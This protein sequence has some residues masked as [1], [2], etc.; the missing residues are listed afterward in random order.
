MSK[1]NTVKGISREIETDQK[2]I[3]LNSGEACIK[4]VKEPD[5]KLS[6]ETTIS[7]D[8]DDV[9]NGLVNSIVVVLSKSE[10]IKEL[11]GLA[12]KLLRNS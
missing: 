7:K 4:F 11:L 10:G 3:I 8:A 2:R 1:E 6:Y 9:V 5:G 12:R